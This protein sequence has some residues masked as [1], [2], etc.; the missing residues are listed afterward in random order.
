M[1]GEKVKDEGKRV[2]NHSRTQLDDALI[3]SYALRG[4]FPIP[5]AL[6]LLKPQKSR[7][8]ESALRGRPFY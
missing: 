3:E 7:N 2:V 5:R 6:P 4:I 8:K 1:R